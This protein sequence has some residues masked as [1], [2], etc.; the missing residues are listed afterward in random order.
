[1]TSGYIG[2]SVLAKLLEYPKF[3]SFNVTAIVRDVKK[4]EKLRALGVKTA[5]GSHSDKPFVEKLAEESDVVI[6]TVSGPSTKA[7]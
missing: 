4:A 5:I 3:R 1:M 2:G 7:W 6:A